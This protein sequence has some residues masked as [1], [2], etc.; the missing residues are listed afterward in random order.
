MS[1]RLPSNGLLWFGV[2][3]GAGAWVVQFL[4]NLA[5]TF[6]QCDQPS[7]RWM[8]PVHGWEIAFS[9]VAAAVV[10][11]AGGVSAWIFLRTFRIDD[12]AAHERRGEGVSPP[13]GR[14]S[15]LS[16]VGLLVNLLALAMIVM[17]GIGAPLLPVCQQS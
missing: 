13:L 4:A 9:L 15:F 2:I 5:L 16:M 11:G 10:L 17:T 6:A 1:D 7:A 3:G 12:V 8:L 14:I